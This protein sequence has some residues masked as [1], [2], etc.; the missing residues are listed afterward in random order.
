MAELT[1]GSLNTAIRQ[2]LNEIP[3]ITARK[4]EPALT[5]SARTGR[6]DA[7][8]RGTVVSLALAPANDLALA[9]LGGATAHA[10]L[11]HCNTFPSSR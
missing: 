4:Q 11:R 10:R 6:S 5:A 7:D 1:T 3:S 2:V 8:D 9:Q